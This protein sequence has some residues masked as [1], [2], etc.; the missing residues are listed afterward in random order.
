MER[1]VY[2]TW[3]RSPLILSLQALG[4]R[5]GDQ[6]ITAAW[7]EGPPQLTLGVSKRNIVR[8]DF[9]FLFWL[10]QNKKYTWDELSV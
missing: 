7:F 10:Q 9:A 4:K 8:I 6:K 5:E 1:Y 3:V 2:Q